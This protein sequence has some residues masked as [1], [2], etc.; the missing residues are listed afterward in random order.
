M[1]LPVPTVRLL[2]PVAAALAIALAWVILL[3]GTATAAIE[4]TTVEA[5]EATGAL[6]ATVKPATVTYGSAVTLSGVL[7]DPAGSVVAGAPVVAEAQTS[8]GLWTV[9]AGPVATD[10]AGQVTL[11]LAPTASSVVRLRHDG[12]GGWALSPPQ[13]VRVRA[14]LSAAPRRPAVEVGKPVRVAGSLAPAPD[15]AVVRLERRV[16]GGWRKVAA[17]SVAADGTWSATVTAGVAGFERY[18]VVRGAAAG[19][20]E[21]TAGLARLDVFRLHRYSVATRGRVTADLKRFRDGVAETYADPRGWRGAHH[22]F[23]EVRRGGDFTVVLAQ[24]ASVPS[25]HPICSAF[26]SCRVG[27]YVIINQDR[28]RS[29]SP[30]FPGELLTYRRMVVNHETGHWLGRGHASCGGEGRLAPVM[31]QQ[32]K[33]L[34]GCRPNPW[35]LPREVRAVSR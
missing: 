10:P 8:D 15:G 21:A 1:P 33:G 2:S 12:D 27:R 35:P 14:A 7:T 6:T 5:T 18:R 17:A 3:S 28:W 13:T 20:G 16:D 9:V 30:Y 29:G 24:A 22:R 4:P 19:V 25:Y 31:A 23:R 26:Y 34:G 32:S 11:P